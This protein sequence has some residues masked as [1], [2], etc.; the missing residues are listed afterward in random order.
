[1]TDHAPTDGRILGSL[2][3]ADGS[4]VVRIEDRFPTSV[5]DLWA[6]LTDPARLARWYGQVD[7]D[8]RLGGTFR[9][10]VV[11]SELEATG[12]VEACE[13]PRHLLVRTRETDES[14]RRG[15][16]VRADRRRQRRSSIRRV[17]ERLREPVPDWL[18]P[19]GLHRG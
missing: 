8:L 2:R 12:R 5:D 9:T 4:G 6:A 16:E 18:D 17:H 15:G 14:Y 11:A 13:A 10:Y 3:S 7:G 19:G 1:M